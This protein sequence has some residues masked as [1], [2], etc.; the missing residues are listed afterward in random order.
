MSVHIDQLTSEVVAEPEPA[1]PG[2]GAEAEE[3]W[4]ALDRVRRSASRIARDRARIC[5]EGFDD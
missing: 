5:A 3:W 4:D 2:G 1:A